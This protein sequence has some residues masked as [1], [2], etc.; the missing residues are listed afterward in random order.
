MGFYVFSQL[1]AEKAPGPPPFDTPTA[2]KFEVML[3]VFAL[4]M[5]VL[6]LFDALKTLR[7]ALFFHYFKCNSQFMLDEHTASLNCEP[8]F[9]YRF[10]FYS[11]SF[12]FTF[13]PYSQSP[14]GTLRGLQISLKLCNVCAY[15]DRIFVV[16]FGNMPTNNTA[17][18]GL[19]R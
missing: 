18:S 10:F 14:D 17:A 9:T 5:F 8:S 2:K 11:I 12:H 4:P 3:H 15:Q 16:L 19:S 1:K 13:T 6:C 7:S